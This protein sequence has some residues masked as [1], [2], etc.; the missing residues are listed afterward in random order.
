[1]LTNSLRHATNTRR[2]F[3]WQAGGGFA[4]LAL[5]DL[6]SRDAQAVEPRSRRAPTGAKDEPMK[7]AV[8]M[9]CPQA[10]QQRQCLHGASPEKGTVDP[11]KSCPLE[12]EIL[13]PGHGAQCTA[14]GL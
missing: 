6:M 5:L 10:G 3:L 11:L 2:E 8:L 1:M 7:R 13:D 4:S 9:P 14:E 12:H